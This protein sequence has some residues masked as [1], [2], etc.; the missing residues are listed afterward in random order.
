MPV[1]L[2][3]V[4]NYGLRYDFLAV[5]TFVGNFFFKLDVSELSQLVL[6]LLLYM[7]HLSR[8]V[9][10]PAFCICKNKDTDQLRGNCDAKQ[11]LCFRYIDST[12]PLLPKYENF[13]PLAILS[14]CTA[15]FVSDQVR[16]PKDRF[17]TTRLIYSCPQ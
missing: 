1:P 14:G 9:R 15:W 3:P 8:V 11:R 17:L 5:F 6:L 4:K 16:K 12:I 10:N 2:C 13:N 7:K